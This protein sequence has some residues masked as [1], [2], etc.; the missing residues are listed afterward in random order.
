M[1]DKENSFLP[2]CKETIQNSDENVS[3]ILRSH[4]LELASNG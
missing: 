1:N 2:S 4:P 3:V